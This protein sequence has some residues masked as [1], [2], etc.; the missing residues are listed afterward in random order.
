MKNGFLALIKTGKNLYQRIFLLFNMIK[1]KFQFSRSNKHLNQ[2][3]LYGHNTALYTE[4]QS[5]GYFDKSWYRLAYK[6]EIEYP[7]DLLLDYIQA[8]IPNGRDPSPYFNTV[9]YR[10]EHDVPPEQAL[11]HF[12][13]SGKVIDSGAYRDEQAL[14]TAQRAFREHS[15]TVLTTDHRLS[16]KPFAV[17]LQCGAGTLWRNWRPS[18][19]QTW[20]LLVN[21]YDATYA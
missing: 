12:L 10:R 5:S 2:A 21:H 6:N 1:K 8:G 11:V 4:I 7:N 18:H 13:R 14:L 15:D 19:D 20:D 16:T 9:L 17:Y 3:Q